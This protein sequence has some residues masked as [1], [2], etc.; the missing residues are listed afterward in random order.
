M[1]AHAFPAV[2]HMQPLRVLY[3]THTAARCGSV[4]SLRYLI[5][6][7]PPGAVEA[8]VMSPDGPAVEA[9]RAAGAR[10]VVIPGVS[11]LQSISGVPMRGWRTLEILRTIWLMRHGRHIRRALREAA[12]DVVHLNERGM[13]QA[14]MIASR[15]GVP[16]VAHARSVM[17]R[18]TK[19][20]SAITG[21]ALN[22]YVAMVVPIDESV[23]RSLPAVRRRQIVYNPLNLPKG[24]A[25]PASDNLVRRTDGR[26]RVT[27]LSGL[28]PYK[29]IWDLL[30]AARR[31]RHRTD[32]V[33]QI[34]GANSRPPSFYRS[35]VGRL[36]QATGLA[37]DVERE[38]RAWIARERVSN[39]ELLGHVE[40]TA[41]LLATT[42]VLVFPSHLNGPGRS[43]FEAGVHGIPS[44]VAL[45]DRIEDVVEDGVTGLIVP[46]RDADALASAIERLVSDSD[47]R[48]RL[49]DQ[50]RRK[51][52]VQFDPRRI[53]VQI[54]DIYRSVLA[55]ARQSAAASRLEPV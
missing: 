41:R 7:L 39:V 44:I 55:D 10:V 4:G 34:A 50:A 33:F 35:P 26:V 11:M 15:A 13:L 28:L 6:N 27:Y 42:D 53:G 40:G 18:R 17:D 48:H 47:L 2:R 9:F 14:A 12:P 19:W 43:V 30:E 45:H 29:G 3:I 5:E 36:A 32:V 37:C 38:V 20:V 46:D 8:T 25:L 16:V 21:I 22:R 23:S 52:A 24:D 1:K 54:L 31:L 49:G 51:Y